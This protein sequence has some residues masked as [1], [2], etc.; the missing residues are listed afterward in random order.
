MKTRMKTRLFILFLTCILSSCEQKDTGIS[1]R[2]TGQWNWK[3]TCGGVVG[4][5]YS[6]PTN[7]KTLKITDSTIELTDNG[8]VTLEREY[9]INDVTDGDNSKVY[10]IEFTDGATWTGT[11][12]NNTLNIDEFSF[13][14]SVYERQE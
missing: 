10:E 12:S 7:V 4:C 5:V 14:S 13:I 8:Q 11:V 9:L 1:T 3:S 6:S 2:L